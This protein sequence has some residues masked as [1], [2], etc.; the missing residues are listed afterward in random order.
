VCEEGGWITTPP[1]SPGAPGYQ[2]GPTYWGDLGE[3]GPVWDGWPQFNRDAATP[4]QQIE[5]GIGIMDANTPD[6]GGICAGW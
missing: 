3:S 1:P 2:H 5:M 4:D 6:Q